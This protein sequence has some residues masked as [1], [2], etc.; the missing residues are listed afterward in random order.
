MCVATPV[1]LSDAL[2]GVR[3]FH[4]EPMPDLRALGVL[5]QNDRLVL[6]IDAKYGVKT[7]AELRATRPALTIAAS[8]DDGT[9]FI[10]HIS[11]R[12][13]AAHGIDESVLASW[14]GRYV[15][16]VRP[17]Q[18]LAAAAEGQADAVLQEA[19]MTPWWREIMECQD[20]LMNALPAEEDALGKL[21]TSLGYR[22]N[23]LPAG[24]W[25]TLE[26]PIA[27]L[28]FSDFAL[29]VR[30]DMPDDIAHLMAWCLVETR[31]ALERGY[32]HLEPRNTAR[33]DCDGAHTCAASSGRRAI[34]PRCRL[35]LI[36]AGIRLR[37][38]VRRARILQ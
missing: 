6:A 38:R 17:D 34:L 1:M 2:A 35:A 23:A 15:T 3:L 7:F 5:S 27:A 10:G 28:A 29:L 24:Y 30:K 8:V 25:S 21:E 31:D 16:S 13:M 33:S 22:R 9:N 14:G 20:R 12:Y 18:A 4:G 26:A 19:I 11:R 32:S 37:R 36:A